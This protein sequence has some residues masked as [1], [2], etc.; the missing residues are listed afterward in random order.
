[1]GFIIDYLES[2]ISFNEIR[3]SFM[4]SARHKDTYEWHTAAIQI[5]FDSLN[6]RD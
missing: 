3:I 4:M 2:N 6:L 5:S 1:M